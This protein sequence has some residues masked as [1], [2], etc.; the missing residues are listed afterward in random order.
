MAC[1]KQKCGDHQFNA[2]VGRDNAEV[3]CLLFVG[4]SKLY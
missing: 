4:N 3:T 2:I 1:E